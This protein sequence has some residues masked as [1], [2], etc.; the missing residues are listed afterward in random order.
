MLKTINIQPALAQMRES[1]KL[2]IA[3][4]AFAAWFLLKPVCHGA[5]ITPAEWK[6]TQTL[7]VV[8][9]GLAELNLPVETLDAARPDLGDVRILDAAS[10]EVP[11]LIDRSLPAPASLRA[12]RSISSALTARATVLAIETGVA[13]AIEGITLSTP[14]A[15]FLKAVQ[16]EGSRDQAGW[17]LLSK[18]QIIFRQPNGTAQLTLPLRTA[19]WPFLRLTIDDER[20]EPVPFTSAHVL[21]A[22]LSGPTESLN[23][24][25]ASRID[26]GGE[27]RLSLSLPGA[28]IHLARLELECPDRLFT[29]EVAAATRTLTEGGITESPLA[30]GVIYRLAANE[31]QSSSNLTLRVERQIPSRELVLLVRNQDST[32]LQFTGVRAERRPVRLVFFAPAA[33]TYQLICGNRQAP[34]PQYDLA[35]LA[36]RLQSASAS[37]CTAGPL[38]TNSTFRAPE[39]LPAVQELGAALDTKDWHF[40]K[41]VNLAGTGIQQLE[42]D[43]EVLSQA[44]HSFADLRIVQDGKQI[45][46]VLERTSISRS[47]TPAVS[48]ADDPKKPQSS[49]WSIVF[50]HRSLPLSRMVC[51]S[52]TPLFQRDVLL[53]EELL[54]DRGM[55]FTQSL[56]QA[57]WKHTPGEQTNELTVTFSTR[58]T[59]NSFLLE[60]DNGDNPPVVLEKFEAFYPATRLHFKVVQAS[61]A[62]LYYG[63]KNASFPRYD[64]SLV[65]TELLAGQ[66]NA[67]SLSA[68]QQLKRSAWGNDESGSTL[69]KMLFWCVLA[70]V[71]IGLVLVLTR[72]LPAK[73]AE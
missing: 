10:L 2:V 12:V 7:T 65:S 30:T 37:H 18:G 26:A 47:L 60:T 45:P 8:Q 55:K 49:R 71:V 59:S 39:P 58:P 62:F 6:F 13:Q 16:I 46:F 51:R 11:C 32:P 61:E 68:A 54:D 36:T 25:I 35:N 23:L 70:A 67:A 53:Y 44:Q 27:T 66:K 19:P 15:R 52:P 28:N 17:E 34:S 14:A 56:G 41:P 43:P 21:A 33:G 73:P 3:A 40:R 31:E 48:K 22:A 42:L 38:S 9:P 63:N 69:G 64:L 20:S 24:P 29:R 4:A 72:Y 5:A 50:P 57:S 1:C